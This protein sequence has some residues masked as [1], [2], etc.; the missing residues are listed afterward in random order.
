[1][2]DEANDNRKKRSDL[3]AQFRDKARQRGEGRFLK[4]VVTTSQLRLRTGTMGLIDKR[5]KHRMEMKSDFF[6]NYCT[7]RLHAVG[8]K[9]IITAD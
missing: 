9:I 2:R 6:D 3:N 8:T 4:V 1:M 7:G 5:C